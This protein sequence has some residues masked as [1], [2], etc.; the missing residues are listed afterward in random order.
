MRPRLHEEESMEMIL[1]TDRDNTT[2]SD[3]D[4]PVQVCIRKNDRMVDDAKIGMTPSIKKMKEHCERL[5]I[6][7]N[8]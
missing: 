4:D 2:T 5:G 7:F 1:D 3:W 6:N 8:Y